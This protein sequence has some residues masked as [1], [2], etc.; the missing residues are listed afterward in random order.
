MYTKG[1]GLEAT[2][3]QGGG[4]S[5]TGQGLRPDA[6]AQGQSLWAWQCDAPRPSAG[7]L[8]PLGQ[9]LLGENRGAEER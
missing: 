3:L 9:D 6:L 7:N 2:R 5:L 1:K 8:G 4:G